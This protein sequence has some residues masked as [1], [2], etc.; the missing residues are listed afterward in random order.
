[1][2]DGPEKQASKAPHAVQVRPLAH[3]AAEALCEFSRSLGF[4]CARV[5]LQGC[6]TKED[7]LARTA[8]A[9]QFPDWFGGNWDAFFDCLADLSWRPAPGHL[10]ILEN[11]GALQRAAPEVFDTAIAVLGDAAQ[12]WQRRKVPVRICVGT[13]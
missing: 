5:D 10:I 4:S 13:D 3:E 8:A 7:F 9:L 6:E 2:T 12:A 11:A 1:M